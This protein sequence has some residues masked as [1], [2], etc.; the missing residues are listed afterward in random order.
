[1]SEETGNRDGQ[2][3]KFNLEEHLKAVE[4]DIASLNDLDVSLMLVEMIKTGS[5]Y[6]CAEFTERL[7]DLVKKYQK[8]T[9]KMPS[10]DLVFV[11][12]DLGS[13]NEKKKGWLR[14]LKAI[15]E[16]YVT[17]SVRSITV[18]GN[19]SIMDIEPNVFASGVK[20]EELK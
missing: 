6:I 20:F 2:G 9:G 13:T 15:L 8:V 18:K 12:E 4:S 14:F 7:D 10:F 19:P 5:D 11:A 3:A 16:G 17:K 1:M